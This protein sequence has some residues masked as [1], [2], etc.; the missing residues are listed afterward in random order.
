MARALLPVNPEQRATV[1]HLLSS[2]RPADPT[3]RLGVL[4]VPPVLP[5]IPWSRPT[6]REGEGAG[7]SPFQSGR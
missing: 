5:L 2:R 3:G 6:D 7:L 4:Q 1:P